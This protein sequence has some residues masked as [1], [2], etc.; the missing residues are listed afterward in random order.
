MQFY[1]K[2]SVEPKPINVS[3]L[4]YGLFEITNIGT[5]SS[6]I[7]SHCR[8]GVLSRMFGHNFIDFQS[9]IKAMK[10]TNN[11]VRVLKFGTCTKK[12]NSNKKSIKKK[13]P[14]NPFINRSVILRTF[15]LFRK[16]KICFLSKINIT[17]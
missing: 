7:D 12:Y 10:W 4:F 13:I 11:E 9:R 16:A 6:L 2:V 1:W 5:I 17:F 3:N 15:S 8:L 14:T